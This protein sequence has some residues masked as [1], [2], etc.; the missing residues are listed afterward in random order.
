[1]HCARGVAV[2]LL[3][4]LRA[5]HLSR[6]PSG[7]ACACSTSSTTS[8]PEAQI[9]DNIDLPS[10]VSAQAI[11]RA[12][13]IDRQAWAAWGVM[14]SPCG[15]RGL[16]CLCTP[17]LQHLQHLEVL[18]EGQ[19]RVADSCMHAAEEPGGH[20]FLHLP[21]LSRIWHALLGGWTGCS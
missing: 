20:G 9:Y 7:R 3:G 14:T 6:G 12:S 19:G 5:Q 18:T 17:L 2:R 10:K 4:S 15:A 21:R 8:R 1:M 16:K 11:W 13:S